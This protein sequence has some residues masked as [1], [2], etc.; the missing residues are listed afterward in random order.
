MFVL[1]G[2]GL[3]SFNGLSRLEDPEF[4]IKD[5]VVITPYPGASAA[6][7]EIEVTDLI[8]RAVQ[9][10]GQLFYVESHSYRDKSLVKVKM[11]DQYDQSKLPQVWDELRRKVSDV[12][13]NLP[14]GAGP[15]IVND[16]F[17]DV[18]GVYVAITGDGHSQKEL[19]ETAKFLRR[20]FL[21][22]GDVKKISFYGVPKE[23]V[24]V[25]IDRRRL[26]ALGIELNQVF[27]TL[28]EKN[29]VAD[30]GYLSAGT[31]RLA[32]NPTGEFSSEK[33]FKNLMV[34]APDGRQVRLGDIAEIYRDYQE[35]LTNILRYDG[36]AAIG[37]AISTVQGGNVVSM[38]QGLEEKIRQILDQVPVGIKLNI[39]SLQSET[40]VQS[41]NDFLVSLGQAV[42][43]PGRNI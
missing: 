19:Y 23:V 37:I 16:D 32:I 7:V 1:L 25:E 2:A 15:S 30:A 43:L 3:I 29:V 10:M 42:A 27:A 41:I 24:Y 22:V 5:A 13:R 11:L 9:E 21:T 8:E 34:S 26:A 18:F 4:T 28:A 14:P 33:E 12:Q 20:E 36:E 39:V 17:G 31:Q 38:G 6:E 35:P 40:V